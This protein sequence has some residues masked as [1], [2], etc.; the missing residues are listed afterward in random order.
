[1]RCRAKLGIITGYSKLET[2]NLK[3]NFAAGSGER[4]RMEEGKFTT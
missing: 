4:E 1:M 3:R 2:G